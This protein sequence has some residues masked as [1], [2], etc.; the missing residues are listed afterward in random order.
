[1]GIGRV[2]TVG[3]NARIEPFHSLLQNNVLDSKKWESQ[4]ELRIAIVNWIEGTYHRR[5]RKRSL[6]KMTPVQ[7]EG[8]HEVVDKELLVA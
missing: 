7:Y 3:D 6:G 1:M 4:E 5:R 8:A 2:A